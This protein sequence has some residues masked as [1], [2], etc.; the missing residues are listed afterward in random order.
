LLVAAWFRRYAEEKKLVFGVDHARSLCT[1]A[2][3]SA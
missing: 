3:M 2:S 1:P